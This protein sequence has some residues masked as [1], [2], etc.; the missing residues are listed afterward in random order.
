MSAVG[1]LWAPA[2]LTAVSTIGGGIAAIYATGDHAKWWW[3]LVVAAAVL[4]L[5][6]GAI[7]T[8]VAEKHHRD[9]P[10]STTAIQQG[11]AEVQQAAAD[12]AT[13]VS[14]KA[15][16][17]SA[18]AWNMGDVNLGQPQKKKSQNQ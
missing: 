1:R 17:G 15:D 9:R 7:W 6:G 12:D 3:W 13:N 18:A 5:V 10:Q 11:G 16:D 8:Y 4:G 14:I 2:T